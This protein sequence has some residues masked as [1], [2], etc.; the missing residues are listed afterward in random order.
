MKQTFVIEI[1]YPDYTVENMINF[2]K[3]SGESEPNKV[4]IEQK[5]VEV[6]KEEFT[7]WILNKESKINFVTCDISDN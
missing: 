7:T 6:F 3:E 4:A 2:A 5:M 1:E